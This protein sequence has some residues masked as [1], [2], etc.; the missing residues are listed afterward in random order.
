M[1]DLHAHLLPGLDDGARSLAEAVE[2]CRLA[3][4]EGCSD[5]VATPHRRRDEWADRSPAA[6]V[7]ALAEL[8]AAVGER[9]RLHLGAEN[10]VDSDLLAEVASGRAGA[11]LPLAGSRYLLL[12]LEPAGCGPDPVV[13]VAA[14]VGRGWFPVIAHPEVTP[15]LVRDPGAAGRLVAAGASLQLTAASLT[16]DFG[17]GPRQRALELVEAGLAHFVASDAHRP[18]WR[19][20]GLARART[21]LERRF[22]AARADQLTRDHAAA[23]LAD[24]PLP[25]AAGAC[26]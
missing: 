7:D 12:E 1:I 5:L 22:G 2:L 13:L 10:R 24:Q 15:C 8:A 16:G 17:P 21:E 19:P 20:T 11:V 25:V 6:L 3:A 4:E 26:R 23:V 14:L 9:P 18:G